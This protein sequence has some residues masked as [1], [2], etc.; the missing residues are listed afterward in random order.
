MSKILT[1]LSRSV[2]FLFGFVVIFSIVACNATK[3][4][5]TSALTYSKDVKKIIDFN[6]G[7]C[8]NSEK[9]A[10]GVDLTTYPKVKEHAINGKLIPAIQHAEGA[11]AMPKKSP[12]LD[13]VYIQTIVGWAT[14][15]ALE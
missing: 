15:G 3:T 11:K 6:C 14:A 12:K 8:H 4:T 1:M 7:G 2:L 10:G 13:D 9:P 5:T